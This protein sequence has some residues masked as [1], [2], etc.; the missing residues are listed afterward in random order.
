MATIIQLK[1]STSG[2]APNTTILA[3]AELAYSQD[4][5]GD[6]A[7]A[8]LYIESIDSGASPVIHKVGGKYYTDI[9]D[10]VVPASFNRANVAFAQA[11]VAFSQA[12]V[13]IN[14]ANVN[15][16]EAN[17]KITVS[18]DQANVA[19]AQA[20][21]SFSQAN[22]SF[23]QA[24]V[25]INQANVNFGESNS[26]ITVAFN[27]A[28]VAFAQANVSFSQANV[29][30][31]AANTAQTVATSAFAQANSNYISAVTKL[32]VTN[33]GA[34]A[35]LLDQYPGNN[36]TIFVRGGETIA[37]DLNVTGHPFMIRLYSGGANYDTGLIHVA[38]DGTVSLGSSAQGK[39]SGTIYWKIPFDIAGSTYVYQCSIHGGM[40]GN[41]VIEQ[42]ITVAQ[43][44]ATKAIA[45]VLAG[46]GITVTGYGATQ[47]N[48]TVNLANTN[49]TSGSYG[50]ATNGVAL[51][52]DAQ[53]R[54]TSAA[55]TT[56]SSILSIAGNSGTDTVTVGIDTLTFTGTGGGISTSVTDNVISFVNTGVKTVTAGLGLSTDLASGNITLVNT[57]VRSI[58]SAGHGIVFDVA[59]GNTTATF[60]GVGKITGTANEIE[61]SQGTGNVIIGLPNDVSIGND[62]TVTG[63]LYVLG[64]AVT[65]NTATVTIEDPLV[66]FGNVTNPSDSLSIGFY[67]QYTSSGAKYAGLYRDHADNGVFKLFKDL[68]TDPTTNVVAEAN[69]TLATL[70]SNLTGGNITSLVNA[71]AV[72]SGGTGRK[73]LTANAVLYGDGTNAVALATGSAGQVLQLTDTG[74]VAFGSIDGGTF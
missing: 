53:G 56:V 37:F 26:K 50:G 41:I 48:V 13:A 9:V 66:K 4:R 34:S 55:N 22:V 52:V 28:N 43:N 35:Y 74:M 40:V 3:E 10:K 2:N 71:I 47:P 65:L 33:S 14:Q 70:K 25:A 1:R 49:V 18:F 57:G 30:F 42:P 62:L 24:N 29:A 72:D 31:N 38:T 20:N 23:A 58:S 61:V 12:N 59:T 36:P 32:S 8:I 7:N 73:T 68:A 51:V 54:I 39:V 67:G 27:Q 63:N 6:G 15:F 60:T 69:F 44:L 46:T 17:S 16:G 5:S 19:F 21:V 11:N 64:D 45:N